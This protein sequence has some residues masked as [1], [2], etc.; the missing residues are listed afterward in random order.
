[1]QWSEPAEEP[2]AAR[3]LEPGGVIDAARGQHAGDAD[4][5]DDHRRPC[6]GTVG[7]DGQQRHQRDGDRDRPAVERAA[8]RGSQQQRDL[9]LV[10]AVVDVAVGVGCPLSAIRRFCQPARRDAVDLGAQGLEYGT[11]RAQL[12]V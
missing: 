2:L 9:G 1:M 4:P 11:L 5:V 6:A 7:S 8:Q 3:R 12:A 10:D